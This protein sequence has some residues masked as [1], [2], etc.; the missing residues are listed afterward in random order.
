[1]QPYEYCRTAHHCIHDCALGIPPVTS[2]S[3]VKELVNVNV[4]SITGFVASTSMSWK[5]HG[6]IYILCLR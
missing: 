6:N 3:G 4:A 5:Y 1:M 2:L